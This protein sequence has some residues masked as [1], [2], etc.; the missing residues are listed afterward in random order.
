MPSL[1]VPLTEEQLTALNSYRTHPE[2]MNPGTGNPK[3]ATVGE[4]VSGE[5]TLLQRALM[6]YPPPAAAAAMATAQAT[7]D[8][9]LRPTIAVVVT[10]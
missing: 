6:A 8:G 10:T 2:M 9:M 4:M 1:T 3:Y 7:R 5:F